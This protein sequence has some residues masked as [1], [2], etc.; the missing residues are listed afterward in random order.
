M[1]RETVPFPAFAAEN[2]RYSEPIDKARKLNSTA[3]IWPAYLYPVVDKTRF[4]IGH[5]AAG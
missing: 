1:N 2:M 4:P 5:A 3:L